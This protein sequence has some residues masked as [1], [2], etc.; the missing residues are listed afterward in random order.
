MNFL[1]EIPQ[2]LSKWLSS[3]DLWQQNSL[4]IL[5]VLGTAAF[6]YW[7]TSTIL[8]SQIKR[9]VDASKTHYDDAL[10][11]VGFFQ[12]L[13]LLVPVVI[14]QW[15]SELISKREFEYLDALWIGRLAEAYFIIVIIQILFSLLNFTE[16]YVFERKVS[17][18]VPIRSF[19]QVLKI[20]ITLFGG[21]YL[22]SVLTQVQ[23]LE[24]FT[25]LGALTAIILLIFKDSILG[26]VAGIQIA[27]N[28][29]VRRGD[30]IE[31]PKYGADGDI[32]EVA[33][34]TVKVRNFDKTIT[35]IPTVAL[36]NEGFKNWRGMSSSGLRRIKRSLLI[37]LTSVRFLTT[38]E[39]E[40]FEK[41]PRLHAHFQSKIKEIGDQ[42]AKSSNGYTPLQ[43]RALTNLGTFRAYLVG[44][45]SELKDIDETS[46]LLVRQKEATSQG[47]G[48]EIYAFS[49]DNRWVEYEGLQSDIFDHIY[50]VLP[51]FGL[52]AFQ[53]ATHWE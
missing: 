28:D 9:A 39:I 29:L 45:L 43:K 46:T 3:F 51:E 16:Q 21:I 22:I 18:S 24:I 4:L 1:F 36:I 38:E 30:W 19:V 12:K 53:S 14:I 17:K 37:D 48:I 8:L 5:G 41:T 23:T 34:T 6:F 49:K 52:K 33:L 31:M 32:I 2:H 35:S 44:Y 7:L 40:K 50:A 27:M 26:F 25:S 20:L 42:H 10:Y 13:T 47:V 15:G 11:E